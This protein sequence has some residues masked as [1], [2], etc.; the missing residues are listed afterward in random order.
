MQ[1]TLLEYFIKHPSLGLIEK[2][3][4][5]KKQVSVH[6]LGGS[7]AAFI[8]SSLLK[9]ETGSHERSVLAICPEKEE[10]EILRDDVE[11]VLGT[12]N[13]RFFPERDIN[14]Y[15]HTDSHFEVRSQRIETLDLLERGWRGVVV[16]S[17]GAVHDPT[18]PP[19]LFELICVEAKKGSTI[20]FDKFVKS[21]IE[22]GFKRR[23]IVSSAGQIA[24]R[25][26]IIDIFPFGG[27]FPYRIEFW[28]DEIES[29]R[30]FSTSSQRSLEEV[31]HF[32]I[33]PPNEFIA[34]AGIT[35]T[36]EQRL[37][38]IEQKAGIDLN[39]LRNAFD[40]NEKQDGIEQ[41]LNT[42]YGPDS[43]LPAHFSEQD[44]AFIFDP[45]RCIHVMEKKLS[46]AQADW[47]RQSDEYPDIPPPEF[48]FQ[49]P[50]DV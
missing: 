6:G 17:A 20:D 47:E 2:A 45:G 4:E 32:R 28:G 9:G 14:P 23:N 26:G 8:I 29:I 33:I 21:L 41:Y 30:I 31:D 38:M 50:N 22:K 25:G 39:W 43:S 36:D 27:D 44:V 46:G 42:V 34:E 40:K 1:Q 5:K 10:A 18:A 12:E 35:S 13:V 48:I 7:S 49:S 19:G 3:L 37:K 24:V 16:A 11:A 15:E